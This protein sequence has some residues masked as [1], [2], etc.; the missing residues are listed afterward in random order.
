MTRHIPRRDA[1]VR[2]GKLLLAT[3]A[4]GV[5]SLAAMA[6]ASGAPVDG[7]LIDHT[8]IYQYPSSELYIISPGGIHTAFL[9]N[10]IGDPDDPITSIAL[11]A[12][13]Y[14]LAHPIN[15]TI[16]QVVGETNRLVNKTGE[17]QPIG[18]SLS[19]SYTK[20]SS[21]NFGVSE[22]IAA[23]I[24][25]TT[26]VGVPGVGQASVEISL[27]STTTISGGTG[28]SDTLASVFNTGVTANVPP[29]SI[30][31]AKLSGMTETFDIPFGWHGVATFSSGQTEDV[32]GSGLFS[33][34]DTGDFLTEI[35]CIS[36][37]GGCPQGP[38]VVIRPGAPV[39]EPASLPLLSLALIGMTAAIRRRAR[40]GCRP[41]PTRLAFPTA[42]GQAGL[43]G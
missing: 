31:E 13:N 12:I 8:S 23:G 29:Q 15:S 19:L 27:T 28:G 3:S 2:I 34:A 25:S 41:A 40:P 10:D 5:L 30:Y 22:A 11:L 16:K 35:D 43:A 4:W 20:T 7:Y 37:P 6:P 14:D 33:G 42:R 17:T 39:P 36:T 1:V 32:D 26:S 38:L 24:K 18:T 21:W 9:G